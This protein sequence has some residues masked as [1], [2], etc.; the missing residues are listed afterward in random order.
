MPVSNI[1][2]ADFD[3]TRRNANTLPALGTVADSA[4]LPMALSTE[5]KAQLGSLTETPPATDTASS[6]LNGRLA[7]IAQNLSTI[8]NSTVA[9]PVFPLPTTPVSGLTS[10]MTGTTSTAVTGVGAAGSGKFNYI[11]QITVANS[12]AT[13]GTNVEL[14]DGNGGTTFYVIPAA[15]V[16][17]GATLSFPTPLKQPTANTALYCKDSTTGASVIVSVTGFQ[18]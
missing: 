2:V 1:D 9:S 18:A 7:R 14:Q 12:H 4:S 6:G 11:T 5:G 15:A 3:G 8:L 17:G 10:A 16:Y 13:V